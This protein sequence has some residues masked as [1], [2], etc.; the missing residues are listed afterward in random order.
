MEKKENRGLRQI[1]VSADASSLG[2]WRQQVIAGQPETGRA[3]AF[4]SD[5]GSYMPGGEGTA[6]TPL[7]Y[8]VSGM[9]L[10]LL[11]HLS[12]VAIKKKLQISNQ[13]VC[14]T[15]HFHEQGS[16]L[17]GDAE[18]FCD[19]FDVEITVDSAAPESEINELIA[20][21]RRMCFAEKALT[22]SVEVSVT[23]KINGQSWED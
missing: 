1:I 18:G 15:A 23:Q 5:E 7:T 13:R 20:I 9:A 17:K 10:C 8:F 19:R 12:Q 2:K 14:V 22:T 11:S 6:P 21:A 16:V 4:I 3:Y